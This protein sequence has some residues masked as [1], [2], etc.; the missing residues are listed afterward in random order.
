MLVLVHKRVLHAAKPHN[1]HQELTLMSPKGMNAAW[2]MDSFTDSS[3]PPTY[4]VVLGLDPF[5][6]VATRVVDMGVQLRRS[7]FPELTS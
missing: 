6:P 3:R 5:P 7:G 1:T 2:R 4:S